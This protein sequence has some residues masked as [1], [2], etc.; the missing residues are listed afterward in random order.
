MN[1]KGTLPTLVLQVLEKGPLHGYV[2]AQE[3]K[4]RSRGTLDFREGTLYPALHTQEKKGHIRSF[5]QVENGRRRRCYKLT[6][7]GLRVLEAE[8]EQWRSLSNAIGLVLE[9]P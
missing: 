7:D 2:I 9:S 1:L 5:E 4:K 3:I 6:A 8:K